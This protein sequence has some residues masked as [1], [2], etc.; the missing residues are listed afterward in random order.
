MTLGCPP[1]G[2]NN[3]AIYF[4]NYG[5]IPGNKKYVHPILVPRH[6]LHHQVYANLMQQVQLINS[7][8]YQENQDL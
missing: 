2:M 3:V 5:K 6:H 1:A 4:A 8:L 7:S